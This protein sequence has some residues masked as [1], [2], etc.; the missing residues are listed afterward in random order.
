MFM[1]SFCTL[2]ASTRRAEILEKNATDVLPSW[3][4]TRSKRSVRHHEV[5]E[6]GAQ[7]CGECGEVSPRQP[8]YRHPED[9]RDQHQVERKH[10][11]RGGDDYSPPT[12][13]E[14][15]IRSRRVV[16]INSVIVVSGSTIESTTWL[17][18]SA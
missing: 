15:P 9:A 4:E 7:T 5:G 6:R 10:H 18:T 17:M 8:R 3:L 16:N 11:G 13:D 1:M 12:G 2:L 14:A